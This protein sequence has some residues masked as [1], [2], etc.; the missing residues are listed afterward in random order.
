MD[1]NCE[2][3]VVE[4]SFPRP[5]LYICIILTYFLGLGSYR[6]HQEHLQKDQHHNQHLCRLP[7]L[8]Q[9][10]LEIQVVRIVAVTKNRIVWQ[11]VPFTWKPGCFVSRH[12]NARQEVH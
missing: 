7:P 5:I 8:P 6:H 9:E 3:G 10:L 1:C 2:T 4:V 12:S 11:N